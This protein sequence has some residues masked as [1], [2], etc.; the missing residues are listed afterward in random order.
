[1]SLA[2]IDNKFL[3]L[4][5]LLFKSH[6]DCILVSLNL[7]SCPGVEL[8]SKKDLNA[9]EPQLAIIS[10]GS[11]PLFNDLDIFKPFLSLIKP[12]IIA[13]LKGALPSNSKD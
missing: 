7:I 3:E 1:M 12:W 13:F 8:P 11:I 6:A 5:N 2:R 4:N 10:I 9:S